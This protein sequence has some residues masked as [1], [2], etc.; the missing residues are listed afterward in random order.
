MHCIPKLNHTAP[1]NSNVLWSRGL[2]KGWCWVLTC[3]RTL[4]VNT[5]MLSQKVKYYA[6]E[7]Q[8]Q[9]IIHQSNA[10][11]ASD[12][13][14]CTFVSVHQ[15]S[16]H[17]ISC[18]THYSHVTHTEVTWLYAI[19]LSL[20]LLCMSFVHSKYWHWNFVLNYLESVWMWWIAQFSSIKVTLNPVQYL[21]ISFYNKWY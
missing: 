9:Q 19:M 5:N 20:Q 8:Y 12:E 4:A 6:R 11:A 17:L 14:S 16:L 2:S 15:N 10:F 18:P 7:L 3:S 21:G 1:F 13:A